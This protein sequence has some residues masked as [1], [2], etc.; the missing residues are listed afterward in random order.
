M[1]A[2]IAKYTEIRSED[3]LSYRPRSSSLNMYLMAGL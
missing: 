1:L 2:R 3:G